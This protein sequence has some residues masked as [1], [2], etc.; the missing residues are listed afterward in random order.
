MRLR[1][2]CIGT[3]GLLIA[4]TV[5]I[6]SGCG[7][8]TDVGIT[9]QSST[10]ESVINT[11]GTAKP[12]T[13]EA[14]P[15]ASKPVELRLAHMFPPA[16]PEGKIYEDFAAKLA[17][18]S[19]GLLKVTVYSQGALLAPPDILEGVKSGAA[20]IGA[21]FLFKPEGFPLSFKFSILMNAP[22]TRSADAAYQALWKQ[23][24]DV[25]ASEWKDFKTLSLTPGMAATL[26]LKNKQVKMLAD[27][28]GLQVR[29][30]D[31]V[32][33]KIFA[34]FGMTS[35]SMSAGDM[36][37][38]LEK[39]TIDGGLN[40]WSS[41]V[42]NKLAVSYA[43]E[44]TNGSMGIPCPLAVVMNKGTYDKLSPALQQVI[45][46]GATWLRQQTIDIWESGQSDAKKAFVDGG[47]KVL[48]LSPEDEAKFVAEFNASRQEI[49]VGLDAQGLSG[50]EIMRLIDTTL[51]GLK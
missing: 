23:F 30:N 31:P 3:L 32:I 13:S 51:A 50:T 17:S 43:L 10:T 29:C 11:G 8:G 27:L 12:S 46:S 38:A 22:D 37:L 42:A 15:P 9:T 48:M 1:Q 47:G 28:K 35:T 7:Q 41:T 4:L 44:L 40:S 36:A 6:V 2:V 26:F 49:A 39:G 19:N 20:D 18:D 5:P 34:K 14:A 21:A 16:S 45:D 24:P 25:M 33:A